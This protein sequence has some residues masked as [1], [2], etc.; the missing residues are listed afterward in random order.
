MATSRSPAPPRSIWPSAAV[1]FWGVSLD[2]AGL[3]RQRCARPWC[4]RSATPNLLW[5]GQGAHCPVSPLSAPG[6]LSA[7]TSKISW[8]PE[9]SH[10]GSVDASWRS[11]NAGLF[12]VAECLPVRLRLHHRGAAS[13]IGGWVRGGRCL[14]DLLL[15]GKGEVL[16]RKSV[17]AW[18]P[19]RG[20]AVRPLTL[21][22]AP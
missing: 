22:G 21:C 17:A 7:S 5:R 16:M 10:R 12:T 14:R 20:A 8:S 11:W 6:L 1:S 2:H 13:S 9:R 19:R 4:V 3:W 18:R 15:P